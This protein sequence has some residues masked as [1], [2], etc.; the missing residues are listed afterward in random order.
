MAPRIWWIFFICGPLLTWPTQVSN[1][2]GDG[3]GA[4][5]YKNWLINGGDNWGWCC[6]KWQ[7][8]S[9]VSDNA[10][11]AIK[12]KSSWLD[13]LDLIQKR[14]R[15][16]IRTKSVRDYWGMRLMFHTRSI[17][18][19]QKNDNLLGEWSP[20]KVCYPFKTDNTLQFLKV[21]TSFLNSTW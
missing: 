12:K 21:E 5:I 8:H 9:F 10:S 3:R 4:Q 7:E 16:E 20:E 1:L 15:L 19:M 14:K 2:F 11:E 18:Y 6:K 13:E 17:Y